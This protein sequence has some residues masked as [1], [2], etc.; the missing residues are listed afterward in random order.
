M[1][2]TDL[3]RVVHRIAHG[4][5]DPHVPPQRLARHRVRLV[6]LSVLVHEMTPQLAVH[7]AHHDDGVALRVRG[8]QVHGDD[9]RV[10]ESS[11]DAG[12]VEELAG[13]LWGAVVLTQRLDRH[14]SAQRALGGRVHLRHPA[15]TELVRDVH[16]HGQVRQV[17]FKPRRLVRDA[18][19]AVDAQGLVVRQERGFVVVGRWRSQ[20]RTTRW[21]RGA[22]LTQDIS[23]STGSCALA[24]AGYSARRQTG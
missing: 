10:F 22:H 7:G 20:R 1:Q 11:E 23:Q 17:H 16:G 21:G 2:Y 19:L 24:C 9:G 15:T 8:K 3:V 6:E 14:A 4:S 5:E 12:L 18:V 13:L